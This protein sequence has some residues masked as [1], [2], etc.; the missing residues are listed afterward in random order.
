M[1]VTLSEQ[2]VQATASPRP[3]W[4]PILELANRLTG[5]WKERYDQVVQAFDRGELGGTVPTYNGF[6]RKI[7]AVGR[8]E[9]IPPAATA[10]GATENRSATSAPAATPPPATST[11]VVDLKISALRTLKQVEERLHHALAELHRRGLVEDA[12]LQK[13]KRLL[14]LGRRSGLTRA[15]AKDVLGIAERYEAQACDHD[16]QGQ[17]GDHLPRPRAPLP[18]P[19]VPPLR[20]VLIRHP[21]SPEP[22]PPIYLQRAYLLGVGSYD[23]R[24]ESS[25]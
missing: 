4:G 1:N 12:E 17:C 5:N 8:S 23:P 25:L 11:R 2:P 9:A 20:R 6:W 19:S 15:N 3:Q 14:K 13:H 22:L 21:V 24:S 10:A 18:V 7:T 16:D